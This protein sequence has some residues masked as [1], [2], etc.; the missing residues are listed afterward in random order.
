MLTEENCCAAV[1]EAF[2]DEIKHKISVLQPFA[3][4]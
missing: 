2:L 1:I 4:F 3:S